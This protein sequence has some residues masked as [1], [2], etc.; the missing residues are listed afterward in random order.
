[1]MQ[2]TDRHSSPS[3]LQASILEGL[4]ARGHKARNS[5]QVS[6]ELPIKD[7]LRGILDAICP[8]IKGAKLQ[9]VSQ[10]PEKLPV[11][12]SHA[13]GPAT[14]AILCERQEDVAPLIIL[15]PQP[16]LAY[17]LEDLFGGEAG[18]ANSDGVPSPTERKLARKIAIALAEVLTP[19]LRTRQV[20]CDSFVFSADKFSDSNMDADVRTI[21]LECDL[22]GN[23]FIIRLAIP[24]SK[25][26]RR[27]EGNSKP[28]TS[29][30]VPSSV[31]MIGKMQVKLVAQMRAENQTLDYLNSL[32]VGDY[33]PIEPADLNEAKILVR[34][35]NLFS[36]RIGKSGENFCLMITHSHS[37]QA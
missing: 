21:E 28:E 31:A 6:T 22:R 25:L 3:N 18:P 5:T 14:A 34:G 37:T 36:A 15:F 26:E 7:I 19:L 35:K 23:M 29:R 24:E 33:L 2:D 16:F 17:L 20:I 8:Q 10:K 1:M 32:K 13:D 30:H 4:I 11:W 27:S 9:L 12:L